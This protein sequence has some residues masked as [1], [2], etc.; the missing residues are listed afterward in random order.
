MAPTGT[1]AGV[2][3]LL[4]KEISAILDSPELRKRFA[5]EGIDAL[6]MSVT[7]FGSFMANEHAKW[8]RVIE[9][10]KIKPE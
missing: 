6:R 3:A 2:V 1:P 9:A 4:H 7:E 8:G 10:G 5:F